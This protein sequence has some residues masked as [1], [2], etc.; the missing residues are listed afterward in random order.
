M[1]KL[2]PPNKALTGI[3]IE[4]TINLE[5][6]FARIISNNIINDKILNY[7][8]YNPIIIK[9]KPNSRDTKGL[10]VIVDV[11]DAWKKHFN[12][13][14]KEVNKVT[15]NLTYNM[16]KNLLSLTQ[17]TTSTTSTPSTDT[18]K[19]TIAAPTDTSSSF[20]VPLSAAYGGGVGAIVDAGTKAIAEQVKRMKSLMKL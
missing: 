18:T 8:P 11:A 9:F 13:I 17:P 19:T 10:S 5:D 7:Y 16:E 6:S 20:E 4:D 12:Y 15:K 2:S 1:T 3:T 14:F